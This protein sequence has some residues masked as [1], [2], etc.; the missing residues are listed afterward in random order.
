SS[1]PLTVLFVVFGQEIIRLWAGPA[2]VP[3][4]S[5]LVW[6]AIWN[7][8]LATMSAGSFLLNAF[9]RLTGMTIY[10]TVTAVTNIALSIV[11]VQKWGVNGVVCASVLSVGLLSYLPIFFEAK[12][13]LQN[14]SVSS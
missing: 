14:V 6:M 7:L 13:A 1:L 9:G 8:M 2:A 4:F 3:A 12:R 11:L 10:G 5:L